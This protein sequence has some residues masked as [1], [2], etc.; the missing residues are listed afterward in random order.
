LLSR[1]TGRHDLS[2]L[3][4]NSN[5]NTLNYISKLTKDP[6]ADFYFAGLNN[7]TVG[8]VSRWNSILAAKAAGF[9]ES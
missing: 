9:T 4:K 7:K 2:L 3:L 8:G 6:L 5:R 1:I